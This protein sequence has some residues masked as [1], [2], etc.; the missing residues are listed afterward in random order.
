MFH[1]RLYQIN[2]SVLIYGFSL[3]NKQIAHRQPFSEKTNCCV[4]CALTMLK[5]SGICTLFIC[6]VKAYLTTAILKN[7]FSS[8]LPVPVKKGVVFVFTSKRRYAVIDPDKHLQVFTPINTKLLLVGLYMLSVLLCAGP[9]YGWGEYSNFKGN[10][11]IKCCCTPISY[12][13]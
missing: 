10:M 2:D 5:W 9:L 3:L 13:L 8:L 12:I 6:C 4:L 1:A 7:I 11:I